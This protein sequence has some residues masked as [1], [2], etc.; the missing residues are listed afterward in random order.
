[1]LCRRGLQAVLLDCNGRL[2]RLAEFSV[3]LHLG[4]KASVS[5]EPVR[6]DLA[7]VCC[8]SLAMRPWIQD[9]GRCQTPQLNALLCANL[10]KAKL[11]TQIAPHNSNLKYGVSGNALA[12]AQRY[13]VPA[14]CLPDLP[15]TRRGVCSLC[16][17]QAPP[18]LNIQAAVKWA[19]LKLT[20]P[21]KRNSSSWRC[22]KE[23]PAHSKADFHT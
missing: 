14:E 12:P 23:L 8:T 16:S 17:L 6:E 1:M 19:Q 10:L 18:L 13:R 22:C 9:F 3:R 7:V 20:L 15:P 5:L 2:E 21:E 11:T 4:L